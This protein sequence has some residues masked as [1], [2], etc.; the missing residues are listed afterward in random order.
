MVGGYVAALLLPLVVLLVVERLQLPAFV[1]EHMIVLLVVG[2]AVRWGLRPAVVTAIVA[3][4]GDN[5]LLRD[6]IGQD[7]LEAD[8][9]RHQHDQGEERG[10]RQPRHRLT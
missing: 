7:D 9:R 3:V 2:C 5:L 6:P 10:P 1:F 4:A 8:D